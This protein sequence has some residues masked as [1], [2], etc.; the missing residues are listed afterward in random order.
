MKIHEYQAKELLQKFHIPVPRGDIARTVEKARSVAE[1]LGTETLVVKAQVHA[2]G[3]GQA[4]G[5]QI[6][7]SPDEVADMAR[8]LLGKSLVT[9]QTGG[10]G[11]K[12]QTVLVEEG[13][14]ICKE[15]YVSIITDRSAGMNA[16]MVSTEGGMDIEEVAAKTP[17]K[18]LIEHIHPATGLLPFQ[19]RKLA[20]SLGLTGKAESMAGRIFENLLRLYTELDASLL[21][22]NPLVLTDEELLICLDAKINFDENAL[23]RHEELTIYKD[24]LAMEEG[25]RIAEEAGL[26]YIPLNGNVGCMVNG[27]G[28]AMATMDIIKHY[29]G[30]PAN[31]LDIG[32]GADAETVAKG[33]EIIVS[34]SGV[35]A[36]LINIFGGIVRCDRVAR[37]I[38]EALKTVNVEIP[39]VVRLKGTNSDVAAD[40]LKKSPLSFIVADTLSDAADKAVQT[41]KSM[42]ES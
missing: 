25:E 42:G 24:P 20:A 29:G 28:L 26:S 6:V 32:G 37:G 18:I 38:I 22:I 16:L 7:R 27:A 5:V 19:K 34:D 8:T 17:K 35:K 12:I 36:I 10:A 14:K 15:F 40:L 41:V 9:R 3:R 31:F 13:I 30:N 21:E 11:K 4:G 2:G 1:W 39:V 23:F 33:F